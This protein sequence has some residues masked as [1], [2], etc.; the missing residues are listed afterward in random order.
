[1][2]TSSK[3]VSLVRAA[4]YVVLGGAVGLFWIVHS[5]RTVMPGVS[6]STITRLMPLCFGTVVSVRQNRK[7]KSA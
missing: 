1:M 6:M 3:N 2:R 5:G 7:Q 4:P